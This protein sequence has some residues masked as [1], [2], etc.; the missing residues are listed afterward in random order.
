MIDQYVR[1]LAGTSQAV[2][3][4]WLGVRY[5]WLVFDPLY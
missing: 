3:W 4:V 2:L 5:G 1:V